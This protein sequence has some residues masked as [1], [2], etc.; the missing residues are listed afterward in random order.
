MLM[1]LSKT[2]KEINQ[3]ENNG[4]HTNKYAEVEI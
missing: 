2:K 1:I 4:F 3:E